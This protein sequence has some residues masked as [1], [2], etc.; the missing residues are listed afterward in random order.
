MAIREGITDKVRAKLK[1]RAPDLDANKVFL[2]ATHTHTAPVM[3]EGRYTL[4][5]EGVMQVADYVDFM[6]TQVADFFA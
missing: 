1:D 4:P 2:S 5:K 6:T 3:L